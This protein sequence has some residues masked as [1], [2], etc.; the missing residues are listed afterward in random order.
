VE[1]AIRRVLRGLKADPYGDLFE[2]RTGERIRKFLSPRWVAARVSLVVYEHRFPDVPW[3]TRDAVKMLEAWLH[4]TQT[5]FEWGSGNGTLWLLKRSKS[6]TSVEH[7][8]AWAESVRKRLFYAG[9]R[10]ADY[11]HVEEAGY[12]DVIDEFPDGH[13]D[14]VIVDGLF[15]D[16]AT[17]KSIPKLRS[18]GLLLIDNANW[19]LPS[20]SKTPLSRTPK[21]G[22]ATPL[23]GQVEKTLSS[24]KRT[25]TTNGVNDT[26]IWVKP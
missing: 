10:N 22:P 3:I 20:D 1:K 16:I 26:A 18:G 4:K 17:S 7:H 24:W 23:W 8:R 9:V 15:R 19:Y 25:W 21:Q 6:V 11:R 12:V 2:H 5:G 13:F 14:Y